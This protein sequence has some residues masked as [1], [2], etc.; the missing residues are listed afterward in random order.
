MPH[1]SN[2]GRQQAYEPYPRDGEADGDRG[3]GDEAGTGSGFPVGSPGPIRF[4]AEAPSMRTD[5]RA[6]G[7]PVGRNVE[8]DLPAVPIPFRD[9]GHTICERHQTV[10]PAPLIAFDDDRPHGKRMAMGEDKPHPDF[11]QTFA[12]DATGT[13][14]AGIRTAVAPIR[15]PDAHAHS[16][17]Q[18]RAC[19]DST[20]PKEP[21]RRT[22]AFLE[23]GPC[24]GDCYT[25]ERANRTNAPIPAPRM[26]QSNRRKRLR[27]QRSEETKRSIGFCSLM[28]DPSDEAAYRRGPRRLIPFSPIPKKPETSDHDRRMV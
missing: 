14:A 27:R 18:N 13:R 5:R 1:S 16:G 7:G 17:W 19:I 23:Q 3:D 22:G 2:G 21:P 10:A 6:F 8:E 9:Q 15:R 26:R 12:A 28:V 25:E 4:L 20:S 24:V 11:C